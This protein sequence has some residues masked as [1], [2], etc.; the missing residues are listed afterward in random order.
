MALPA[1]LA[2]RSLAAT[3]GSVAPR[4]MIVTD[5][6]DLA[7]ALEHHISIVWSDAECRVHAPLISGRL[8][9]AFS[10]FGYDAVLLDHRSERGRGEQ[11]LENFLYRTGFAPI[12]YLAPGDDPAL[13]ARVV[14]R[15]AIDCVVRER[16]DHRR[17]LTHCAMPFSAAA[18]SWRCIAPDERRSRS[19]VSVRCRFWDTV[20]L[21]SSQLAARRWFI[22]PKASAPA[23]WWC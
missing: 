11:W 23:T 6:T 9:S 17:S 10:A 3:S 16:I 2:S 4:L 15:G 20:S 7:R 8:H 5:H 22:S 19:H 1:S 12:V 13:A 21:V 18:S 14:D